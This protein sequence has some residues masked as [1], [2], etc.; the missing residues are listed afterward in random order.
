MEDLSSEIMHLFS[1][2]CCPTTS[3]NIPLSRYI[4]PNLA[5]DSAT[6]SLFQPYSLQSLGNYVDVMVRFHFQNQPQKS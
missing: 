1:Y 4:P 3:F 5:L 2:L 6:T